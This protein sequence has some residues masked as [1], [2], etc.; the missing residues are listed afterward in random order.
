MTSLQFL[1]FEIFIKRARI[2]YGTSKSTKSLTSCEIFFC[3]RGGVELFFY[4]VFSRDKK[5]RERRPDPLPRFFYEAKG[6]AQ[7]ILKRVV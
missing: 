5:K 6:H 7:I 3:V 2:P 1:T 4:P